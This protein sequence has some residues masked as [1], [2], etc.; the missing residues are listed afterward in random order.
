MIHTIYNIL[1]S[2]YPNLFFTK[3]LL[4]LGMIL[5]F[6]IIYKLTEPPKQPFE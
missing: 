3:L 1:T 6:I 4:I 2:K 5:G